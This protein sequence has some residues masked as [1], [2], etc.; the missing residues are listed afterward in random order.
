MMLRFLL[1]TALL[2]LTFV[3]ATATAA[4]VVTADRADGVYAV[5]DD[6]T[7]TVR[8]DGDAPPAAAVSYKVKWGAMTERAAGS[9]DLAG[10]PKT[11]TAG[12][13]GPGTLYLEVG[14]APARVV[15]GVIASPGRIEPSAPPP[16]DFWEFWRGQI[17]RLNAIPPNAVLQTVAVDKPGVDYAKVTLDNIDGSKV[18]GQIARPSVGDKFPALLVVQWAGV[19]GLE[20]DWV[21]N[22]AA[23][24][25]L[26][27]NIEAHDLP[28]DE[29]AAFYQKQLDGPLKDYAAIGNESRETS[30]F[31]RM[32]LSCYRAAAYLTGRPDWDGR[33]LVVSG[34]SQGGL[35]ALM[36]AAVFPQVTAALADVPAGCDALG[37]EVGRLGGW[38]Q[39]WAKTYGGR[40]AAAVR[41]AARY[42]DVVNF[43]PRITCP[44]LIGA[45][46]CDEI[47]PAAGV[48]AAANA[49]KGPVEL[50]LMP[51]AE[52]QEVDGSHDP[53]DDRAWGAWL[54]ALR[55]GKPPPVQA[56][57]ATAP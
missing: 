44:V 16:P 53:F 30:Y 11:V 56:R 45:G 50:H 25:W 10:G 35:Q 38:P 42:F 4:V 19:Y 20:K 17:A 3:A 13:D 15:V 37:P 31:L 43:A 22:P 8:W 39:Q 51:R 7:W 46:F 34:G 57:A 48:V 26:V 33:V 40:D 1:L 52:H 54:P 18:R 49:I 41:Q 9:L 32:Y 55:Q 5:G 14:E 21:V 2:P 23:D 24:G 28:I 36:T 12:F 6:V 29:P 47:C 27:M